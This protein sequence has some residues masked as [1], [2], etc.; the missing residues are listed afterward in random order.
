MQKYEE[1]IINELDSIGCDEYRRDGKILKVDK[2]IYSKEIDSNGMYK[3]IGYITRPLKGELLTDDFIL[4][5]NNKELLKFI[6]YYLGIFDKVQN[7]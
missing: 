7:R 4:S 3:L 2:V 1:K 6:V 5:L